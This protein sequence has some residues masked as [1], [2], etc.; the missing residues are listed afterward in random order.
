MKKE[1]IDY[2]SPSLKLIELDMRNRLCEGSDTAKGNTES[3]YE[4]DL[5]DGGFHII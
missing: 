4:E 2:R 1:N 5:E 3:I